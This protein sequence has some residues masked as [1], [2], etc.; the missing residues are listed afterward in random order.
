MK[1]A[2]TLFALFISVNTQAEILN[3][4]LEQR[5]ASLIEEAIAKN[6]GVYNLVEVK[7]D[8]EEIRVDN[9][10][11]DKKFESLFVGLKRLDQNIFDQYQVTV[12]SEYADAYDHEAR[13]WGIF[14]VT[15]VACE[16]I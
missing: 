3:T 14:S 5:H 9:G 8:V 16:A 2:F 10:I 15:N 13:D 1:K 12:K 7:T 11:T 6:C 4:T